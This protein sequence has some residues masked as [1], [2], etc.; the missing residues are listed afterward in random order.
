MSLES[1]EP[2]AVVAPP[3]L[4]RPE[5][6]PE[7]RSAADLLPARTPEE[8]RAV[9]A[10]F[11]Q[12]DKEAVTAAGLWGMWTGALILHDVMVDTFTDPA[13]EVEVEP[14]KKKTKD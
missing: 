3:K 5:P 12:H 8:I 11:T 9:E 4:T 13:G 1:H 14:K 6:P 2:I 10:V 7:V